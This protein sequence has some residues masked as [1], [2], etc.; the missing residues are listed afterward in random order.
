MK[1]TGETLDLQFVFLI[2]TLGRQHAPLLFAQRPFNL[3][4]IGLQHRIIDNLGLRRV[5][6]DCVRTNGNAT[7]A[8]VLEEDATPEQVAENFGLIIQALKE[9]NPNMPIIVCQVFPSSATKKRPADKIKKVNELYADTIRDNAQV[10]F[11]DTRKLFA[12][13]GGDAKIEEFPDLLH[14]NK[15]GYAK[16]AAALRPLLATCGFLETED[17]QFE[18]EDGFESLF[19]GNDLSGWCYLPTSVKML[20]SRDRWKKR[21]EWPVVKEKVSFD[22]ATESSDGRYLAKHGRLIVAEAPGLR[23]IQQLWTTREFGSDFTL[24]LE[25]RDEYFSPRR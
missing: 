15:A 1:R 19:N 21:P 10:Q 14:P 18:I 2:L 5:Q 23:K 11:L 25:F 8:G 17:D 22:S 3:R 6:L 16:W 12:N 13:K 24:R 9:H 20:K 4:N 7:T